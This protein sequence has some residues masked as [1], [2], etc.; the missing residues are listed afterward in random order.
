MASHITYNPL[1]QETGRNETV[2]T[3]AKAALG[4]T[5]YHHVVWK[6]RKLETYNTLGQLAHYIDVENP[7][8]AAATKT[9]TWSIEAE[10][11]DD[12][13]QLNSFKEQTI[14]KD[15]DDGGTVNLTNTTVREKTHYNARGLALSY[16]E[17]QT[18]SDAPDLDI[19][20]DMAAMTYNNLD[21]LLT[22]SQTVKD[23][24]KNA[25]HRSPF[26]DL[27]RRPND[28]WV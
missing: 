20:T 21:L 23:P 16:R 7:S 27:Q 11:Y 28:R 9:T 3:T 19:T 10:G 6:T 2:T 1:N 18:K 4:K 8:D 24:A 26:N 13:G 5:D 12:Q 17:T 15:P 25:G 14:I 22:Y